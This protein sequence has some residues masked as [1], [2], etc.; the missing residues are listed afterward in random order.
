M[1]RS[2]AYRKSSE[3]QYERKTRKTTMS[4]RKTRPTLLIPK[5]VPK[6]CRYCGRLKPVQGMEGGMYCEKMKSDSTAETCGDFFPFTALAG[7]KP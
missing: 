2:M 5:K 7:K 4:D 6:L 3:K 1:S